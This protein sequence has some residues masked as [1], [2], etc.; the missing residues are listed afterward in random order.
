MVAGL[1][2]GCVGYSGGVLLLEEG[3]D[4]R[5]GLAG[6][7]VE[8]CDYV[9]R[10]VLEMLLAERVGGSMEGERTSPNNRLNIVSLIYLVSCG[11]LQLLGVEQL[12]KSSMG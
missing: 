6:G 3:K 4:A 11:G 8:E 1:V 12:I 2:F 5:R 7:L 9:L 10:T